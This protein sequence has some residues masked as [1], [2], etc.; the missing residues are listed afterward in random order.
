MTCRATLLALLSAFLLSPAFALQP[1]LV[2]EEGPNVYVWTEM[3]RFNEGTLPHSDGILLSNFGT[4]VFDPLNSEGKGYILALTEDGPMMAVPPDGHLNAPKG[5]GVKHDRLFIAD[6]GCVM[7]YHLRKKEVPPIR[8][9]FPDA[10]VFVNDVIVLNDMVLV[11]VTNTG[12]LYLI[13]FEHADQLHTAVPKL[14]GTIPGA[15]GLAEWSGTLYV[16]SYNPNEV[17]NEQNVIYSIDLTAEDPE[18]VNLIGDRVGQ[19]DGLAVTPDG[20]RLYFSNW[21]NAEG[22]P[23]IGYVDLGGGENQVH[24]LDLP[25]ELTGPADISI[26]DGFLY[27]P[28]LPSHQ[29]FI[30]E[31]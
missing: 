16:A 28:D 30:I 14:V 21:K 20:K 7:V 25:I 8:I 18:P 27:V 4:D 12:N 11:S 24:V 13:D 5:M 2:S 1:V 29:L 9:D 26:M 19:Y 23:E 17:P 22:K 15:N 31:L 6:V 3:L 10:D